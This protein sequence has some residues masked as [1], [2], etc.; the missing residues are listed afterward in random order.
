MKRL[1][2]SALG[3]VTT[4]IGFYHTFF[5]KGP[6]VYGVILFL[7]GLTAILFNLFQPKP[8]EVFENK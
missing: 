3:Y 4:G 7:L 8:N 2:M 6:V 1:A 5:G